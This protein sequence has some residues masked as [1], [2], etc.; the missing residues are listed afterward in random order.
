MPPLPG[1]PKTGRKAPEGH[2]DSLEVDHWIEF[3]GLDDSGKQQG[4]VFPRG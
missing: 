1:W 3:V 2:W 4:R